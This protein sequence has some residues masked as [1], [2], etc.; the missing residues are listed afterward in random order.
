MGSN[1]VAAT[2]RCLCCHTACLHV[3]AA[4]LYVCWYLVTCLHV[5]ECMF[6]S[7]YLLLFAF[8]RNVFLYINV[9]VFGNFNVHYKDWLA[10]SGETDRPGEF[11]YHFFYFKRPSQP[12]NFPIWIPGCDSHNPAL[13]NVFLFS[14]P[15]ICYTPC[16]FLHWKI[17]VMLSQFPLA[18]F[19][20]QKGMS[21]LIK[22][23][24][25]I[26]VVIGT[27]FVII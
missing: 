12:I 26:L 14:D 27:I 17:M 5:F 15:S 19:Q 18:F 6:V 11:C 9:F 20:T 24:V 2:F 25:T 4:C 10:Y 13:L 3:S 22:Q 1:P 16:H 8:A 23:L 21:L 7:A